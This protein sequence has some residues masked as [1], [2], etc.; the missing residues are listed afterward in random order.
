MDD[1][2]EL[3]EMDMGREEDRNAPDGKSRNAPLEID[4]VQ[5]GSSRA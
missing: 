2:D 5:P 3:E 1:M 4:G